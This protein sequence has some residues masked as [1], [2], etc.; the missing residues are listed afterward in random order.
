M[1]YAETQ[2]GDRAY[3]FPQGVAFCPCCRELLIPKC[4]EINVWHWAHQSNMDCDS[5]YEGETYWHRDWKELVPL[6]QREVTIGSHRADIVGKDGLIIELQ[7]TC[8]APDVIWE[9]ERFYQAMIWLFDVADCL[10]HFDFRDKGNYWT[11]R[12]KWPRLHIAYT[13]C[14]TYLDLGDGRLFDL[15]KMYSETP[16]GGWGYFTTRAAFIRAYLEGAN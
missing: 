1:L 11:F 14:P 16:C 7:H 3:A 9:R 4:G 12:W 5:W 10:D 6:E 13:T 8:I 2:D 15:R